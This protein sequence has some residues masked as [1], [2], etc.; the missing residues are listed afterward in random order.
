[1]RESAS[2]EERFWAKVDEPDNQG[3][4][5]WTACT[6]KDGRGRFNPSGNP[7][8]AHT[9]IYEQTIGPV[10]VGMVLDHECHNRDLACAGGVTC[11]HRRCMTVEHM[12]PKTIAENV[13]AGVFSRRVQQF[14]LVE[15]CE[16]PAKAKGM[17]GTHYERVARG[18]VVD[19]PI[20]KTHC[21]RGHPYDEVNTIVV[22]TTGERRCRICTNNQAREYQRG[23]RMRLQAELREWAFCS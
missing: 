20:Q 11:K 18:A 3:C 15:G 19:A 21:L 12:T 4:R 14:C 1:M 6:T 17:C 23:K 13:R 8:Y 22:S 5:L 7:R 10:P 16:R 9:W 2:A